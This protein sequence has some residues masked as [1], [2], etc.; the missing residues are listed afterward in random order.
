VDT[1]LSPGL[2]LVELVAAVALWWES[3]LELTFSR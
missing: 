3:Q 1:F 2:L